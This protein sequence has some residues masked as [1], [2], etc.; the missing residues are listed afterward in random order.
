[1]TLLH[2]SDTHGHH[3]RL[4]DLP[5]ADVV[6]HSGDITENGTARE[7]LDFLEWFC[8]L[9]HPHKLFIAGNHDACLCDAAING[10]PADVHYLC[11]SGVE[12]EGLRFW[13]IPMLLTDV[14]SGKYLSEIKCIPDGTDVLITHEPPFDILDEADSIH[15]GNQ[16]LLERVKEIKP[17][18]HLFGH[19]HANYGLLKQNDVVYSNASLFSEYNQLN[20]PRLFLLQ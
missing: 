2:L 7:A 11:Y 8:D 3:R 17:R 12:I 1:M 13:G 10:L 16:E 15:Y 4:T 5:Q 6:V 14:L 20:N 9:P 19:V 18:Y